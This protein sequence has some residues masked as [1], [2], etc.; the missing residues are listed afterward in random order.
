MSSRSFPPAGPI[1]FSMGTKIGIAVCLEAVPARR[2]LS[3]WAILIAASVA[4][5]AT[6]QAAVLVRITESGGNVTATLSGSLDVSNPNYSGYWQGVGLHPTAGVVAFGTGNRTHADAWTGLIDA[7]SNLVF[8]TANVSWDADSASGDLFVCD[9]L[10]TYSGPIGGQP[11]FYLPFGYGGG[12]LSG[13]LVFLGKSFADLGILPGTYTSGISGGH[14]SVTYDI[15]VPEI[16]PAGMG[17]VLA[18]VAVAFGLIERR[19]LKTKAA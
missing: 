5:A 7:P 13:T 15:S 8:G 19:R 17:A 6:A 3:F 14:D 12:S 18:L 1:R 2:K 16:D 10:G 11:S 4:H 9:P